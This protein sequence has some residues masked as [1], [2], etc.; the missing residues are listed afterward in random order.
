MIERIR[1]D[2]PEAKP[3]LDEMDAICARGRA[4]MVTAKDPIVRGLNPTIF[5]WLTEDE[6]DRMSALQLQL[7]LKSAAEAQADVR[8]KRAERKAQRE[9]RSV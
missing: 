5:D 6:R 7:R 8:R 9:T 1:D 3:I 4:R 2:L